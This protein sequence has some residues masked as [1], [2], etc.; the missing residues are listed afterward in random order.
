MYNTLTG[1]TFAI[2]FFVYYGEV[3]LR[4]TR[5]LY[6][7]IAQKCAQWAH[8]FRAISVYLSKLAAAKL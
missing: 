2:V 6:N 8:A 1:V 7:T 3:A 4:I 5:G